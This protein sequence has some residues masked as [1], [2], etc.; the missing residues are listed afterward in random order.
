MT[1]QPNGKSPRPQF[2]LE[3]DPATRGF[4]TKMDKGIPTNELIGAIEIIKTQLIMM[5]VAQMNAQAAQQR[6][7]GVE[8]ATEMP[9]SPNFG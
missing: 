1:D 4:R 6:S 2:V 5:Q 7:Q 3:Y 9:P 8:L